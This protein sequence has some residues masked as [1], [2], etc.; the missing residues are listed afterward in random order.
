ML[1]RNFLV[2]EHESGRFAN[3]ETDAAE[4]MGP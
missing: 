3:P 1:A 4:N 2:L